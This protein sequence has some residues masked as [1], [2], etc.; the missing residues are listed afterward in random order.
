MCDFERVEAKKPTMGSTPAKRTTL[1]CIRYRNVP[2]FIEY[3]V[4]KCL[5]ATLLFASQTDRHQDIALPLLH[6]H[7]LAPGNKWKKNINQ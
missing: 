4:C 6:N 1:T 2:L 5:L 3:D 7:A